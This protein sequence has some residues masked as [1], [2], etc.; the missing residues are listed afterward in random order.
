[1]EN[2][3]NDFYY[4]VEIYEGDYTTGVVFTFDDLE[5]AEEFMRLCISN[6]YSVMCVRRTKER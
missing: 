4:A 3:N 5:S 2:V 1:M 6:D